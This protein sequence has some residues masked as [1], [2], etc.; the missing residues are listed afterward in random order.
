MVLPYAPVSATVLAI[1][2]ARIFW[3]W[4]EI[5]RNRRQGQCATSSRRKNPPVPTLIV[6]GSGGHTTEMLFMVQRLSPK[7][8]HPIHYCKASS[9]STTFDRLQTAQKNAIGN[10][11]QSIHQNPILIHDIPRSREVGQSYWTSAISTIYALMFA[12]VMVARI[13]PRLVLCNGPGTCIPVCFSVLMFRILGY[14]PSC[15]IVF[16]ESFCR[17]QTLSLTGKLLYRTADLFVVHW[18]ELQYKY[19]DAVLTSSFVVNQ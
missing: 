19:P 1:L 5:R 6:L 16:I 11:N 2:F 10:S 3:V 15:R 17:V 8:Y 18:K 12:V 7:F 13:R 14:M 9:D 4:H